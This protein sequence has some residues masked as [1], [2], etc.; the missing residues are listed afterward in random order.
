MFGISKWVARWIGK[1]D[2]IMQMAERVAGRSRLAVWQRVAQRLA[3]LNAAEARGY[4][5]ARAAAVV[6]QETALL[7][8]QEGRK[9]AE[10][11]ER[12][13][14]AALGL[15]THAMLAQIHHRAVETACRRAA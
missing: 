15:L 2:Q 6:H 5:R 10:I 14:T 3:S 1:R 12:V 9:V 13:E 4:L 8:E 7:I 11:R